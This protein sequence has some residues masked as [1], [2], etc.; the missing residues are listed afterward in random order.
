MS[1]RIATRSLTT[2]WQCFFSCHRNHP[3]NIRVNGT[4]SV[5]GVGTLAFVSLSDAMRFDHA[6]LMAAHHG[7]NCYDQVSRIGDDTL[8]RVRPL[9]DQGDE[10]DPTPDNACEKFLRF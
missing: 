3:G 2:S 10:R 5:P 6:L 9:V 1:L 7:Q 4:R 8:R